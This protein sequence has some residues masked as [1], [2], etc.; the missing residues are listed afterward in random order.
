MTFRLNFLL[1]CLVHIVW[2]VLYL[3][4]FEVL[5]LH[6]SRIG[7]WD[8]YPYLLF[9]GTYLLLNSVVNGLFLN[10]AADLA[11]RIRTG[12]LDAD[13]VKPVDEQFL[14][15]CRR[16]DWAL[17]PQVVLG[18]ALVLIA[19]A[20]LDQPWTLLDG[21]TYLLLAGAGLALLYS[22]VVLLASAGFWFTSREGLFDLW[23][24]L[25]EVVRIPTDLVRG[26][27]LGVSVRF[28]LLPVLPVFVAVNVPARFG[29]RLPGEPW[30]LLLFAA[31]AIA[32]LV[33]SRCVFRRGLVSYRS[34]GS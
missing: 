32:A 24:A 12:D 17:L 30:Q 7:D 34:T 21:L 8:K 16:I 29:A 5:F 28:A 22:A 15:T 10:N 4:F 14:L 18:A 6:I 26:N 9:Q 2:I 20:H 31:G 25:L 3:A 11:D 33:V 19:A 1:R 13:L 27:A 23:F